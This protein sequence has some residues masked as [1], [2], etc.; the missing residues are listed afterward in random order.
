MGHSSSSS[1]KALIILLAVLGVGSLFIALA[2][3]RLGLD[4]NAV[5]GA[6]RIFLA[7]LGIGLLLVSLE[8][9]FQARLRPFWSKIAQTYEAIARWVANRRIVRWV[10]KTKERVSAWP[11][12]QALFGTPLK[13]LIWGMGIIIIVATGWYV[14]LYLNNA[15]ARD[16]IHTGYYEELAQAFQ[17]GQTSLLVDPPAALLKLSD[18]YD[19]QQRQNIGGVIWDATLYHGKYYLYWGP[20][21]ALLVVAVKA[22]TSFAGADDKLILAFTWGYML[23]SLLLVSI[24]WW[25]YFRSHPVWLAVGAGVMAAF[26]Y[27]MCFL[28]TDPNVYEAAIAGGQC[29]LM[30]GFSSW[31]WH[32]EVK[33]FHHGCLGWPVFR[34]DWPSAAG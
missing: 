10:K 18:P 7:V 2:A 6:K 26:N 30:A 33:N 13:R 21:P 20:V 31:F 15:T 1:R 16:G 4:H 3:N 23:F 28:V 29:F 27:T 12:V 25:R 22:F 24:I 34:W 5:W 19:Y 32:W 17:K 11:W 9:I 8:L 14:T